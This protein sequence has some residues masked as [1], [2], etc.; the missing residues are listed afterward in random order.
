M[1]TSSPYRTFT[2]EEWSRLDSHPDFPFSQIDLTKLQALNEPLT[3]A[4]ISDIYL[5]LCRL[6]Q[7]HIT[8]FRRL[9]N[10]YDVFFHK[11][12]HN[13]PYVIGIA[14]SVAVGKSTTARVLQKLLSM[15]EGCPKVDLLTT[16][17][18]L[19]PNAELEDRGILDRKGFPE[20]Y[21]A[22]R[23]INFLFSVKSGR[24]LLEVPTY[25]HLF[26][27]IMPEE[28]QLIDQP[29]ILIIEGI[30]VLQGERSNAR[31]QIFVSDFFDFSIY[32]DAQ[33]S[34]IR[35][36]YIDRFLKLQN[37]AFA[38]PESYFYRFHDLP[39][40]EAVALANKIWEEINLKNLV[41]N[42]APTK[43]R[44]HLILEKGD[45][46]SMRAVRLRKV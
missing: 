18:F 35:Q 21:D 43:F 27:D 44:S 13:V 17:G 4:E 2:R 32:V 11:T 20:S 9:H 41:E 38:N 42:I 25:S 22:R 5:P 7:I 34:D 10:E 46:H 30:N 16:D 29:D 14:G 23:L 8:H 33:E 6:L 40:T 31:R 24:R 36:W 3:E 37:T 39:H 15:A 28:K 26:Y 12:T 45:D 1:N 19:Y